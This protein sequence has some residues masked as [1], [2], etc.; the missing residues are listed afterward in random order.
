MTDPTNPQPLQWSTSPSAK[1]KSSVQRSVTQL[2]DE[3]APE[4]VLKRVGELR[5]SVE[6]HRTP[7]GCVLQAEDYAVSVSWFAD[8]TK[9]AVLGELHVLV[10]RGKVARRGN[11]RPPKGATVVADLTLQ[12]IEPATDNCV[13]QATDGTRY[14]TASLAAKC[15]ALLEAQIGP[16]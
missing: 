16:R 2:L 15:L 1:A 5:G 6:Q 8:P 9:E 3:L 12:P 4:R 7:S 11:T 14:D 10:W 13:W